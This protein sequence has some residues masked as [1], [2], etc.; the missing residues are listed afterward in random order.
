MICSSKILHSHQVD[1]R[2]FSNLKNQLSLLNLHDGNLIPERL[3]HELFMQNFKLSL[4]SSQLYQLLLPLFLHAPELGI[5]LTRSLRYVR[6][7]NFCS[8]LDFYQYLPF[9]SQAYKNASS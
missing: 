8:F 9:K 1:A 2:L 4:S 5:T 7:D 3:F 6:F